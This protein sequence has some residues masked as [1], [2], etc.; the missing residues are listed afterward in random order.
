MKQIHTSKVKFCRNINTNEGC[1]Y[2]DNCWYS[3]QQANNDNSETK[4]NNG[5][6]NKDMIKKIIETME[7]MTE[8]I[9]ELEQKK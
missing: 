3:H 6:T 1:K 9:S 5:E 2:G 7:K 4:D 8:R